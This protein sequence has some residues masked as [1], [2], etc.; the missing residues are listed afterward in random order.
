MN[1]SVIPVLD[2]VFDI[3]FARYRR[4]MG[5]SDIIAPWRLA[6]NTVAGYV[7]SAFTG[8]TVVLVLVVGSSAGIG[9][10]AD[11]RHW[12]QITAVLTWIIVATWL[13]RR[14]QS[15]LIRPALL[16][17]NESHEEK[18][19]V[20]KFRAICIVLLFAVA[21]LGFLLRKVG[22]SAFRGL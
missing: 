11:H 6:R 17:P 8:L 4:K 16:A 13:N 1:M 10:K 14:F 20:F 15:V 18:Y 3:M 22:V 19:L 9:A 2:R 21:V 7:A 5:D 12:A